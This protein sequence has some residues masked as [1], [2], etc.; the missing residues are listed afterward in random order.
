VVLL[1]AASTCYQ[2]GRTRSVHCQKKSCVTFSPFSQLTNPPLQALADTMALRPRPWPR[3]KNISPKWYT[4]THFLLNSLKTRSYYYEVWISMVNK[5]QPWAPWN[6]CALWFQVAQHHLQIQN[7]CYS[8]AHSCVLPSHVAPCAACRPWIF[9]ING[10]LCFLKIMEAE[11][12]RKKDDWR[13]HFKEKMI[14][15]EAHHHRKTWIR[16]WR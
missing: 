11:W 15:E 8:Q 9:F 5:Q 16:A 4:L 3:R 2:K 10:V 13:C 6:Q 14:Q 12:R 7:A 1:R